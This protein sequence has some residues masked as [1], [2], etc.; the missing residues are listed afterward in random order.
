MQY[1]LSI[2]TFMK[3]H[4]ALFCIMFS[5]SVFADIL[6]KNDSD[7]FTGSINQYIVD[8]RG[9]T[10]TIEKSLENVEGM[11]LYIAFVKM[12][13]TSGGLVS[14]TLYYED[15]NELGTDS[16]YV[17]LDGDQWNV[18]DFRLESDVDDGVSES[19]DFYYN[20]V[21]FKKILNSKEFAFKVGNFIAYVDLT[22]LPLSKFE[23]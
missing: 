19:Y 17:L 20:E 22:K 11:F 3:I 15:W 8:S 9:E 18:H 6:F 4:F 21:D 7:K 1:S 13:D 10:V 5:T 12:D 2:I 16:A 14:L 23:F